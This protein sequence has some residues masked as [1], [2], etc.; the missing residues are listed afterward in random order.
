MPSQG[1]GELYKIEDWR[2]SKKS[3]NHLNECDFPELAGDRY[4]DLLIRRDNPE[5][6]FSRVDIREESGGPVARLGLLG[7][8]CIGSPD[9]G[10]TSASRS[11]VAR[12]LFSRDSSSSGCSDINQSIQRFWEIETYGFKGNDIRIC[13]EEEQLAMKKVKEYV[14]YSRSTCRYKVGVPWKEDQPTLSDNRE[15]AVSRLRSME[16]KLKK[17]QLI[18][19]EYRETINT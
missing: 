14:T 11:H 17:D 9:G 4:V 18:E 6:H 10:N 19:A 5:L 8:T 15:A 2:Q 1:N 12:T 3:W 7:W 16:R 13:T